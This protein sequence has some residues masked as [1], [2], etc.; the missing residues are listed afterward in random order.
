MRPKLMPFMN[1]PFSGSHID[2]LEGPVNVVAPT[3]VTN[4]EFTRVLGRV[5]LRPTIMPMP[6]FA[7][8]LALGEMA[9]ELLLSSQRVRPTRLLETQ[10]GFR[11]RELEP[12][13]RHILGRD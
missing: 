7:A 5:L 11:H 6:A 10:Y 9:N 4:A 2:S 8:R 1:V 12:A 13:L 3:P